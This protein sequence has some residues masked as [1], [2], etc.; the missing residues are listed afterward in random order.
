[1]QILILCLRLQVSVQITVRLFF[2]P[3]LAQTLF[4]CFAT[5]K[6]IVHLNTIMI[7]FVG[8]KIS[9]PYVDD[10]GEC[11]KGLKR[12]NPLHLDKPMYD[13][14][15]RIWLSNG[16]PDKI[17]RSFDEEVMIIRAEWNVL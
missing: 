3:C 8:V 4:A 6:A 9:A 7:V 10:Y 1:M 11:D 2:P 16:I 5:E 14:L 15:E 12:G 17:S 13:E